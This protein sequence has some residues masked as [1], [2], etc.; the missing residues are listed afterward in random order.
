MLNSIGI[1]I[2]F[3]VSVYHFLR[4]KISQYFA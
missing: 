1:L 2:T 4:D 3:L